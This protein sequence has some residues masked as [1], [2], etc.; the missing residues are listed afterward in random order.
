MA[1]GTLSKRI[2]R[3]SAPDSLAAGPAVAVGALAGVA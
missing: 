2:K 1:C 3:C